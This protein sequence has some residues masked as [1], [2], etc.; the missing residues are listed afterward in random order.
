MDGLE[1]IIESGGRGLKLF[2]LQEVNK[3][4]KET[5]CFNWDHVL[6]TR[7]YDFLFQYVIVCY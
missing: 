1:T 7:S 4:L 5:P 6:V 3:G 2:G